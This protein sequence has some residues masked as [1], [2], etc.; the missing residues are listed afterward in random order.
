MPN[1][2][3]MKVRRGLRSIK[4]QAFFIMVSEGGGQVHAPAG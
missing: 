4:T 3:A 2:Y 1:H